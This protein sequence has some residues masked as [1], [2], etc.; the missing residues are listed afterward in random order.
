VEGTL[1]QMEETIDALSRKVAGQTL[2]ASVDAVPQ[3]RPSFSAASGSFRHKGYRC[4][5]L[6][7]LH[8][9]VVIRRARYRCSKSGKMICPLDSILDLP[10]CG[11]T[12]SLSRRALRLA[13][14]TSFGPLQ[15]E[16]WIHHG[17][18]LSDSTL[19][20]LMQ[21]A[22]GVAEQDRQAEITQLSSASAGLHREELL[23]VDR[24]DSVPS[25]LYVSCDGVMY[26]TRYRELDAENPKERKLI[27]QE[28]KAGTVFWQDRND[29][30]HKQVIS[31]RDKPEQFGL[32]L[33][34]LA[35][36]C[37]M[38]QAAEVIFISDGGSW[39]NT[40][41]EMYFKDATRILD[42]YHLSEHIWA[43]GRQ[44]YPDDAKGAKRWVSTCLTHLHDSSGMGLLRHL[45]RSR[46]V[47]TAS[48]QAIIDE[49]VGYVRPRVAITDYVDYRAAGYVIGS[50]MMES[51]CKQLVSQRL[52][53]PGM[54]WSERGALAMTALVAH[55]LNGTWDRFWGSRPL[56][57]A[58]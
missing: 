28:M 18:R 44:L 41:A 11:V 5:T 33:W 38:L 55:R 58:A 57:R 45:E 36:R 32:S 7:G 13:T 46:K 37:G 52:K 29:R 12:V 17:V 50:G 9:P 51:T 19:D 22:G 4:R 1:E 53:G 21:E 14:F 48:G 2:Q 16:L 23:T 27:Y 10:G 49:L 15:E 35:V 25:R 26:C 3:S 47:R 40:V 56:Q 30:W 39:C 34:A 42:W 24:V 54:Q 6:I 43:A 8:G 20:M 31:G